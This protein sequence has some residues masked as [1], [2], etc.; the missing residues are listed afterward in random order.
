MSGVDVTGTIFS[1][2]SPGELR[3]MPA[4]SVGWPDEKVATLC[5][6]TKTTLRTHTRHIYQKLN[7]KTR[8][9]LAVAWAQFALLIEIAERN[10]IKPIDIIRAH[11]PDLLQD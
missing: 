1:R 9:E 3:L 7:V 6:I 8:A 2:L 4:L 5:F 10:N 11:R